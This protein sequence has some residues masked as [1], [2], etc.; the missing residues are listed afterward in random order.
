[1]K[2]TSLILFVFLVLSL[3]ACRSTKS[4]PNGHSLLAKN[5]VNLQ[6]SEGKLSVSEIQGVIRQQPNH[7]VIGIPFRLMVY[8]SV[9]SAKIAD[10][11]FR[12]N[13]K[14]TVKETKREK[15]IASINAK[16]IE[17]AKKR[18]DNITPKS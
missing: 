15:K 17:R 14:I 13:Q 9:D 8:N 12:K 4:V 11:R 1:M 6:L 16:R 10:K 2:H 18:K 7:T 3:G 5:V